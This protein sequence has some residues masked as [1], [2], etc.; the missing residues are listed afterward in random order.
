[1][2][3]RIIKDEK[4]HYQVMHPDGTRFTVPKKGISKEMH[5]KIQGMPKL[6]DG[7]L[8]S[9]QTMEDMAKMERS[10]P[11][12][13]FD[14]EI[15]SIQNRLNAPNTMGSEE[16]VPLANKLAQLKTVQQSIIDAK[17]NPT[18]PG[19]I[20][21][22]AGDIVGSRAPAMSELDQSAGQAPE[23]ISS[24]SPTPSKEQ[25]KPEPEAPSVVPEANQPT[26]MPGMMAQ[27]KQGLAG[28]MQALG[29]AQTDYERSLKSAQ[30]DIDTRQA[31]L[32]TY[33][34]Q[35]DKEADQFAE[36]N[37]IDPSRYWQ[38]MSTGNKI[39]SAIALLVGGLGAG[40]GDGKNHAMEMINKAIDQDI[41]AQKENRNSLYNNLINKHKR[42][43]MALTASKAD[44]LQQV[45]NALNLYGAQAKTA[46]G[47]AAIAKIMNDVQM[48]QQAYKQY[49]QK[50]NAEDFITAQAANGA[51]LT[52][53]E[54]QFLPKD[55]RERF[56]N[57]AGFASRPEGAAKLRETKSNADDIESLL[58]RMTMIRKAHSGGTALPGEVATEAQSLGQMLIGKLREPVLGPGTMQESEYKRLQSVIPTDVSAFWSTDANT[59]KKLDVLR[60]VIRNNLD[61]KFKSEG[62]RVKERP[63]PVS[64]KTIPGMQEG[65]ILNK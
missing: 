18:P 31:A 40:L 41:D 19:A 6:Y 30:N 28:E 49:Y 55:E 27:K 32:R 4:D 50:K 54:I 65:L 46:E 39:Q 33:I 53:Q 57:G 59:I 35:A 47:K 20:M 25:T 24:V 48:Q 56:I 45:S 10:D 15:E 29:Q 44:A 26:T 5:D 21:N 23:K 17:Q 14:S 42:H 60:D 38:N 43:E 34:D 52:P 64:E 36:A 51:K 9:D 22:K 3:Y 61:N 13:P 63:K 58:D 37:K 1:M 11:A 62:I 2:A 7:G 16:A 12:T 8:I